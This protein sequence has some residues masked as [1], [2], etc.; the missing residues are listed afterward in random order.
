MGTSTD[1]DGETP[2]EKRVNSQNKKW[3][4]FCGACRPPRA[5]TTLGPASGPSGSNPIQAERRH[6]ERLLAQKVILQRNAALLAERS[7]VGSQC[8]RVWVELLRSGLS[9][10][11]VK[12]KKGLSYGQH[13][14]A[15]LNS[16]AVMR[17]CKN[18]VSAHQRPQ[19]LPSRSLHHLFEWKNCSSYCFGTATAE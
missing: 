3:A 15:S 2:Q 13:F 18:I 1:D 19:C 4:R 14:F 12:K 11:A 16:L 9:H 17:I 7:K 8:S 6:S 5:D 10:G